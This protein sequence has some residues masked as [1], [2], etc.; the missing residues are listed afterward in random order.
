MIRTA[1]FAALSALAINLAGCDRH[2]APNP[3]TSETGAEASSEPLVDTVAP[4]PSATPTAE[5]KEPG[6]PSE[7]RDPREV[8]A[9]WAKAIETRDWR[10]VRSY[11]GNKGA[12][13][14]LD[15][16]AF[17]LKWSDLVAPE[18]EVGTGEQEGAAGSLYYTAPVTITDGKRVVKG[19][20][21][22]RR[23]NDVDGATPEQLRWHIES[24]T[25]D[26]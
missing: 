5:L 26:W 20:V 10:T 4:A 16:V 13:S 25:L 3:M 6:V 1:L 8:L 12:V 15:E 7:S 11:W 22:M 19:T 23:V 21:T 14:G 24:S 18:V 9:A 17:S 2:S